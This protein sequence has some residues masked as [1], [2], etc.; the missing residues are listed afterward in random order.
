V[1]RDFPM[2]GRQG[3]LTH[4][5]DCWQEPFAWVRMVTVGSCRVYVAKLAKS[6]SKGDHVVIVPTDAQWVDE[7]LRLVLSIEVEE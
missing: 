5:D 3:L 6:Y 7:R 4:L 2:A 1:S